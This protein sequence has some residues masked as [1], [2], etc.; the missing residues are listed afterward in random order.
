MRD[1]LSAAMLTLSV[2]VLAAQP[3]TFA[4]RDS[5]FVVSSTASGAVRKDGP[6]LAVTLARH[7]LRAGKESKTPTKVIGYRVGLARNNAQGFWDIERWSDV[8]PVQASMAT[9]DTKQLPT[10][11]S[12]IPIDNLPSLRGTWLVIQVEVQREG[13]V[14]S[15][16]SHSSELTLD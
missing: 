5:G 8:V 16:Y 6:F 14:G 3:M 9:G 7:T 11:L 2:P 10:T 15:T 4:P 13:V 12:L 1:I